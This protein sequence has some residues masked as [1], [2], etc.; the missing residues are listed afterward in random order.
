MIDCN[1]GWGNIISLVKNDFEYFKNYLIFFDTDLST[2]ENFDKL[3]E[4]F[5]GTP[6]KNNE[7]YF[8][9][10]STDNLN[11]IYIEKIMWEYISNLDATHPFFKSEIAVSHPIHHRMIVENGPF[12]QEFDKFD[13]E[14]KKIKEWFLNYKWICDT[15]IYF[16]FSDN[17]EIFISFA[18]KVE[19]IYMKS[20]I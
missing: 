18:Q 8:I 16:Y 17:E 5:R 1:M 20:I 13:K 4:Y 19:K 11:G 15:A 7:N 14:S 2:N 3:E 9:L 12:S 6:F 10:P